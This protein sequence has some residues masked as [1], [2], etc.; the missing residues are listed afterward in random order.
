MMDIARKNFATDTKDDVGILNFTICYDIYLIFLQPP[1]VLA[2]STLLQVID[3]FA[4]TNH[5]VSH[6]VISD[7]ISEIYT[8]ILLL[9]VLC[10]H[11]RV[12]SH[13]R[14]ALVADVWFS[15]C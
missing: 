2:G 10:E 14:Y 15:A 7:N 13:R 11:A 12:E 3:K 6:E 9:W 5:K 4:L 8:I 1:E